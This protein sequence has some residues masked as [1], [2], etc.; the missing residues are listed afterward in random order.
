MTCPNRTSFNNLCIILTSTYGKNDFLIG[1]T[2]KIF[3]FFTNLPPQT[4]HDFLH[5]F[6][7]N[8]GFSQHS[9]LFAQLAQDPPTFASSSQVPMVKIFLQWTT[10]NWII[11]FD[12][13]F[14]EIIICC[15]GNG[16][17]LI[18]ENVNFYKHAPSIAIKVYENLPKS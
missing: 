15:L 4:L 10:Q 13:T 8:V 14:A 12:P 11:F 17:F 2:F 16:I 7:I 3:W 6:N 5:F 1:N 18:K 9:P